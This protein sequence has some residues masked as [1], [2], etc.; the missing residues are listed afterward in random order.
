M[1]EGPARTRQKA[2]SR[3]RYYAAIAAA[4]VTGAGVA[5]GATAGAA[6][7][8][9]REASS[10][11]VPAS[12]LVFAPPTATPIKHL[13]VIFD[14]N[15]SFD[16]YFGTYP[17]AANTD[18]SP[19]QAKP[20][21]PTVNGLYT[22]IT[23]SGP[24]GPL[25]TDNPNTSQPDAAHPLAGSHLRPGPRVHAGAGSGQRREDGQVR[26]VHRDLDLHRD[27]D[28]PVRRARAGH[29]LLRRQHGHRAVELR[30][31]LRDER[32]QLRHRV[33]PVHAGRAEPDLGPDAVT[34]TR[35]NPPPPA[36]R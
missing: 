7:A 11:T 20:G 1:G 10:V 24:T 2:K 14:E 17:Y 6:S 26:P 12:S 9:P 13:V 16:H 25:L 23:S 29:G 30:A 27:T 8:A 18:G 5:V 22:S 33:R 3:V 34:A 4:A 21:T 28:H 31:E 36:R 19:F 35:S 15:V 32:Q